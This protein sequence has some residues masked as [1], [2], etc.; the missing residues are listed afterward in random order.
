MAIEPDLRRTCPVFI[1]I[2]DPIIVPTTIEIPDIK[3][4]SLFSSVFPPISSC[5]DLL[6]NY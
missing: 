4:I 2:P 1:N 6:A 3:P 5:N